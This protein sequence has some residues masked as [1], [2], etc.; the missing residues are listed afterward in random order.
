M[1][2]PPV[3]LPEDDFGERLQFA[4]ILWARASPATDTPGALHSSTNARLAL[5]L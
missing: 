2:T 3:G 4:L 1:L 5:L